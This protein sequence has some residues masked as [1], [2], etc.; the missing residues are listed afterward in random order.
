MQFHYDLRIAGLCFRLYSPFPLRLPEYFRPFLAAEVFPAEP[1]VI[2]RVETGDLQGREQTTD[3]VIQR[4]YWDHGKYIYRL[5]V[6][7]VPEEIIIVIPPEF[8]K[9]FAQNANW[10]LYLALERPLL[11]HG[12]LV[13]HASAVLYHGKAYLFTAPSGGGKSTQAEIWERALHAQVINGDKVV[14]HDNGTELIAYGSPIAGSSGIYRNICAPVAAIVQ[15][16]KGSKNTVIPLTTRER[17]LLL[18]SEAVKSEQDPDFNKA[19]LQLAASYPQHAEYVRLSCVPDRS[20][21]DC[22]LQY[23]NT[24]ETRIVT[25]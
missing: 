21:A 4:I 1:D 14:L 18:Y 22:L 24:K 25:R 16:E 19:L 23:L 9:Q 15:L 11:H 7:R 5:E 10:L 12:R 17:Y 8:Q 13:L 3:T 6:N 20:A 2:V